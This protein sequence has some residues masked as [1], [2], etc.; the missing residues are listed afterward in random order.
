VVLAVAPNNSLLLINDQVRQ[1]FYLYNA[2]AGGFTSFGGLGNAAAWTP[3]SKTLYITDNAALG[4]SHTDTLYVYSQFSGWSTYPL[5]PSPLPAAAIPPGTLPANVGVSSTF[6]TPALTIPGVGAYLRGTPTVAH[7]WCPIG[8]VTSAGSV[9]TALYPGPYPGPVSTQGGDSQPVQSDALAATTDGKHILGAA[10]QG[11]GITLS[12]IAVTIPTGACS[13]STTGT[14]ASQVQT[15]IP[16]TIGHATTP[17]TQAA[18]TVNATSINQVVPSPVSNLAFITYNGNSTGAQLP[19]YL[20]AASGA[21]T[22]GYVT[23]AGA[24]AVTAPLAGAFTADDSLFFVAT[25]GDNKIH[26]ISIPA[27]PSAATPPTD[28][29]QISPNLPACTPVSAGGND[30]GCTFTGSGTVV[31]VTAIG[32]VPR[33]TT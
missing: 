1:L 27:N 25:A 24:S 29:Q 18:L 11:G 31:P 3:D 15:L 33:S 9:I 22:V 7:A 17:Y 2:S 13:Q 4:G 10:M 23:L 30:V 20:P 28:S 8:T 16:L 12:D 19:Y 32:V 14:G 21:G 6:Q 26:Y 5:P